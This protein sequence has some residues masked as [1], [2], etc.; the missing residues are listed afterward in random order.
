[1]SGVGNRMVREACCL[2]VYVMF[3]R[4]RAARSLW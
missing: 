2:Y 3:V 1:M 4:L